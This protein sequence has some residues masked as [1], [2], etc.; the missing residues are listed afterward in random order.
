MS[1]IFGA[2]VAARNAMYDG[3][4]FR[5][6]RLQRPV[7]SIGNISVG[8]TGKTP[9]TIMLGELLKKRG[10]TFD[11]LSRGYRRKTSGVRVVAAQ[12]S[13][14]DFGDEPVLIARRL[15]VPVLVGERRIDAGMEAERRFAPQMHLLDDGFQH[16]Q[17]A[18]D[19]DIVLVSAED[20]NAGLLPFGRLREPLR[21]LRRADVIVLD[22]R[23]DARQLGLRAGQ[24]VWRIRR[25]LKLERVAGQP[26]VFCGI[27]RPERFFSQVRDSGV[28]AAAEVT[29]RDHH[30]YREVDVK[31]LLETARDKRADGF[32]TTAKDEVNL[33][34]WAAQLQPLSVAEVTMEMLEADKAV[35]FLL[36]KV[37][38]PTA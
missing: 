17:L 32:V 38:V 4:T 15:E 24:Q 1:A 10:V 8:G 21:A 20:L 35:D 3:G 33:G 28:G 9:F 16:R 30:R 7:V 14:E 2:V 5:A 6:R 25:G 37:G 22:E 31:R 13:A 29:F 18:R 27:A 19:V 11:V 34:A 12:G 26:L 36:K 23:F